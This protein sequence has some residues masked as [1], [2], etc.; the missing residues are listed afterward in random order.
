MRFPVYGASVGRSFLKDLKLYVT[1]KEDFGDALSILFPNRIRQEN[2]RSVLVQSVSG[3]V[4]TDAEFPV[5]R[6]ELESPTLTV[7]FV[8]VGAIFGVMLWLILRGR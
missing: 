4:S 1:F 8:I 5:D 6:I 2:G 7:I 3:A